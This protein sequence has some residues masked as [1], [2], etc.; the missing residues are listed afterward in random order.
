MGPA[1]Q[2]VRLVRAAL[3]AGLR[4]VCALQDLVNDAGVLARVVVQG[5]GEAA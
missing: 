5:P 3:E 4:A 2:G 1:A